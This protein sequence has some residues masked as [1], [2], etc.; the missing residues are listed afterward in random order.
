M[1]TK[2]YI[3]FPRNSISRHSNLRR[4]IHIQQESYRLVFLYL[5][6]PSPLLLLLLSLESALLFN[7]ISK[8]TLIITS[9]LLTWSV[10]NVQAGTLRIPP[11]MV[12]ATNGQPTN[13]VYGNPSIHHEHD[14]HD[15][16]SAYHHPITTA[17]TCNDNRSGYIVSRKVQTSQPSVSSTTKVH[18]PVAGAEA[19]SVPSNTKHENPVSQHGN[20]TQPNY[21]ASKPN[22]TTTKPS[23]LPTPRP[24][25]KFDTGCD[26]DTETE[27]EYYDE[28][29]LPTSIKKKE[30]E[31]EDDC[32][33]ST[34]NAIPKHPKRTAVKPTR[35]Q[36]P[37]FNATTDNCTE[38]EI[39]PANIYRNQSTTTTTNTTT[40]TTTTIT[41]NT[42]TVPHNANKSTNTR[43]FANRTSP[44]D[45]PVSIP[46][47]KNK[48]GPTST[49][50]TVTT[51]KTNTTTTT[52]TTT[53]CGCKNQTASASTPVSYSPPRSTVVKQAPPRKQQVA[54]S[55]PV[56]REKQP[57]RHYPSTDLSLPCSESELDPVSSSPSVD[58]YPDTNRLPASIQPS[59]TNTNRVASSTNGATKPRTPH[60]PYTYRGPD[61]PI[62]DDTPSHKNNNISP[63]GIRAYSG[64]GALNAASNTNTT[65]PSFSSF[66][67][68][69]VSFDYTVLMSTLVIPT[70]CWLLLLTS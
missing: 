41:T 60:N 17:C 62:S 55:Y 36:Q 51:T 61:L 6:L 7:M 53:A 50:P 11:I 18:V 69:R 20:A 48:T 52:T 27:Y 15:R 49:L 56:K 19:I 29:T 63:L 25:T 70:L 21:I 2:C 37:S 57:I 40:I 13:E 33:E 31:E 12:P 44:M 8:S 45:H 64:E 65:S 9:L 47:V 30:K 38:G 28:A 32:G 26:S 10:I 16:G 39:A 24:A 3:Y 34:S 5:L 43:P 14:D 23:A 4:L 66:S 68:M 67:S 1:N 59:S 35:K 46:H 42:S 58:I 54:Q 22:A